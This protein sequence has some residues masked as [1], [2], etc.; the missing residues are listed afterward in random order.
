MD[1]SRQVFIDLLERD[2]ARSGLSR[3]SEVSVV[4][5]Q[6]ALRRPPSP[7]EE[8]QAFD[9]FT[10][11]ALNF[12]VARLEICSKRNELRLFRRGRESQS[13]PSAERVGRRIKALLFIDWAG[14]SALLGGLELASGMYYLRDRDSYLG[15]KCLSKPERAQQLR[16]VADLSLYFAVPGFSA[17]RGA[18]F[19]ALCALSTEVR[20]EFFKRYG[21]ELHAITSI[22]ASG[23]HSPVLNRLGFG[24]ARFNMVGRTGATS[25]SH[26]SRETIAAARALCERSSDAYQNPNVRALNTVSDA[27]RMSGLSRRDYL[28][29]A[30]PRAIYTVK[31]GHAP[32]PSI[33]TLF[34]Y[35]KAR[36]M[37]K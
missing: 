25:L 15:W 2:M 9:G 18:K 20:S 11:D 16:R 30:P 19:I 10:H 21:E 32:A 7:I 27:L 12:G 36:W 28:D 3:S 35:W 6:S 31:L 37:A 24:R 26:L 29:V 17:L 1:Y 34:S 4:A 5:W 14:R 23:L 8:N 22:C 13:Y 33:Q